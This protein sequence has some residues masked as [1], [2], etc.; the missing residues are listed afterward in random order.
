MNKLKDCKIFEATYYQC[1]HCKVSWRESDKD[2]CG[3]DRQ[4][5]TELFTGW[6]YQFAWWEYEPLDL[7]AH[8]PFQ[9]KNEAYHHAVDHEY[10]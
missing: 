2:H 5:Q 3:C 9:T 8:G 6:W 7:P 4:G 1:E 10:C